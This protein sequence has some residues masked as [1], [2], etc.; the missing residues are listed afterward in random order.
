MSHEQSETIERPSGAYNVYGGTQYPLNPV[1]G[2]EQARY[3]TVPQAVN[4]AQWRSRMGGGPEG[5]QSPTYG[6]QPQPQ[7]EYIGYLKQVIQ[8]LS[9]ERLGALFAPGM[10]LMK[11][12]Q[13][14]WN[15]TRMAPNLMSERGSIGGFSRP[16]IQGPRSTTDPGGFNVPVSKLEQQISSIGDETMPGTEDLI[17]KRYNYIEAMEGLQEIDNARRGLLGPVQQ[18]EAN[19]FVASAPQLKELVERTAE[20][21]HGMRSDM[22]NRLH[23]IGFEYTHSPT[24]KGDMMKPLFPETN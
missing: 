24:D 23:P 5:G 2:F 4:A 20:Q 18:M 22:L 3:A 14:A 9:D 10:G 17:R 12:P 6:F 7:P 13:V 8:A 21:M 11:A 15:A 16:N 19:K 1:F